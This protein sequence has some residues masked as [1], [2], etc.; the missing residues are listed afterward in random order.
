MTTQ[1]ENKAEITLFTIPISNLMPM[2]CR[3]VNL[4]M[5]QSWF[6]P[7]PANPLPNRNPDM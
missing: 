5:F 6:S 7:F 2:I 4:V 1:T 3:D